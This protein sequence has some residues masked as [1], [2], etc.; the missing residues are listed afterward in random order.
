MV[1]IPCIGKNRPRT[2]SSPPLAVKPRILL[3][4]PDFSYLVVLK[5]RGDYVLLLTAYCVE[6]A[7]HRRKLKK[8]CAEY[9]MPRKG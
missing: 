5:D 9:T 3:A 2:E 7:H 8:E 1:F 6:H 4:P